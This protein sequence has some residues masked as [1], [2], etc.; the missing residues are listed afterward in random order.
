M[1]NAGVLNGALGDEVLIF[2]MCSL[3]LSS[4]ELCEA[5]ILNG[6]L[7]DEILMLDIMCT[8]YLSLWTL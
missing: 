1:S 5:A 7:G 6:S 2:G 8:L 4:C 3:Y